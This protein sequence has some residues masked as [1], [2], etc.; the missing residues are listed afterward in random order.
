MKKTIIALTV[1]GVCLSAT[2]TATANE[3][4]LIKVDPAK[5]IPNQYIVVFKKSP[6]SASFSA[7]QQL[8]ATESM[9]QSI[10]SSSSAELLSVYS[11]PAMQGMALKANKQQIK[12]VLNNPDVEFVEE[13]QVVSIDFDPST[14][15]NQSNATWGLDRID[16][17][18]LPL[19]G[20][21]NYDFDGTGVT[22]YVIDT[23]VRNSHS[24][25]G[26]RSSNG[27]DFIDNDG[28]S[29]DCNG[30][31]THV[32][33]TIGGSTYG[34]AK[35]VSIVG[36]K[37]LGCT[38][39]GSTSGVIQGINWVANQA[40]SDGGP[41]VAN[42]SLGGGISTATDNA[43]ENAVSSGIT[44]VVA[45]GNDNSSACNYS[46]ARAPSA[47][48]VG[49]TTS[50]DARS[51]FSN[52]GSCLDIY[53]PGSSITS[54]W[55]TSNSATNTIS[56]TS[57][58]SPHVAG[59]VALILDENP[60]Y[61]PSQVVTSLTNN[62]SN[63]KV[64][65]AKAGSPNKLLFSDGGGIITPPD[66]VLYNGV[67][68]NL[69]GGQGSEKFYT[70][71]VPAGQNALSFV[72]S[73]GS[74]DADLYVRFGAKPN[75]ST[76][77]CRPYRNGNAENCDFTNPQAGTWHVM[78]RGYTAYSNTSLTGAY[79]QDPGNGDS[80]TKT[81]SGGTGSE[82]RFDFTVPASA[83]SLEVVLTGGSGD[84]DLYVRKGAQPTTSQFDCRPYRNG[85]EETC[86][87]NASVP[88]QWYVMLR[89]YTSY[90]NAKVTATWS[91]QS[92]S[93]SVCQSA[94]PWDEYQSY[95]PGDFV[96]KGRKIYKATHWSTGAAPGSAIAWSSW[97][98]VD[99]CDK[100]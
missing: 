62:A 67:P 93:T 17:R 91:G 44:F 3:T 79:S 1:A 13:D 61:S 65:D 83:S 76:Y 40:Q 25:F 20:S 6:H 70:L 15:A 9:A 22:A 63:N 46:P 82:N 52:Y 58:A 26:G 75:T 2:A 32:A 68:V 49:S 10:V 95:Q 66:D 38:G 99:S 29:N 87:F 90:S 69:S 28:T 96:S 80:I 50:S 41:S 30:H 100:K 4:K 77:D 5:K 55:H 78:V 73:G 57:M 14:Q 19:N 27:Y 56:G 8:Y 23:G 12:E 7:S 86:T 98:Q 11:S 94:Q 31:G 53:A 54:A 85:N 92:V 42:M 89:G 18:D 45:A 88:G 72:T 84:A 21:Y 37:V 36:V 64:S 74:G 48:T 35:N 81:Y 16:Q 71:D 24:E 51:S 34:V 43:V 60:S 97:Q 47:V 39:S 59:V 33:G